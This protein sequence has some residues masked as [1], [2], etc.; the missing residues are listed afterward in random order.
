MPDFFPPVYGGCMLHVGGGSS[1]GLWTSDVTGQL[2][3]VWKNTK[4]YSWFV[5]LEEASQ[6]NLQGAR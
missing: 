5:G 1:E 6:Y 2:R 4:P 3:L